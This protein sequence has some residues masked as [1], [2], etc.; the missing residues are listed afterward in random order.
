MTW[1]ITDLAVLA[2][3]IISAVIMSKKG[4]V[5][6]IYKVASVVISIVLVMALTTPFYNFFCKLEIADKIDE[7]VEEKIVDDEEEK[8]EK[9]GLIPEFLSESIEEYTVVTVTGLV[10]KVIC[11][12]ILYFL[13]K[14]ILY[15]IFFILHHASKLPIVNTVNKILGAGVGLIWGVII[16]YIACGVLFV[17]NMN[18]FVESTYI[19]KWFYNENILIG[20]FV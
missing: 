8:E 13:I 12:I 9:E 18:E 5:N 14:L 7:Y 10:K 1:I 17:L 20:F 15:A 16:I 6:C 11:A 19:L 4:L 3:L 2:V